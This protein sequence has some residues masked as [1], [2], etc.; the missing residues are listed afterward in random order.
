MESSGRVLSPC[1]HSTRSASAWVAASL[2]WC[3]VP[4]VRGPGVWPMGPVLCQERGLG[5]VSA[6]GQSALLHGDGRKYLLSVR[7]G[8]DI[9]KNREE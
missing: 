6:G 1:C 5:P 8:R 4:W 7:A 2:E 9:G 3:A